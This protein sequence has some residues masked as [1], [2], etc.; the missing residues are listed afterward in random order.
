[1]S[2]STEILVGINPEHTVKIAANC[3]LEFE[4]AFMEHHRCVFRAARSV[5]R[6]AAL[7]EDVTQEVF[8]RLYRDP[9]RVKDPELLR[10]WLVRV[11]LNLARNMVR[12]NIRANTRDGSYV[13][14]QGIETQDSVENDYEQKAAVNDIARAVARIREPHRSCLILK[15][16]GFSYKEIAETLSVAES[17]VGTFIARAR[18]E[19]LKL[20]EGRT[21]IQ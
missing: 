21:N 4:E 7:A 11:A 2:D 19:F 6:D 3:P 10:P 12:G 16:Q 17:S 8:I 18:K 13:K 15:Q 5:V 1:M 9:E 20:Y 14:E